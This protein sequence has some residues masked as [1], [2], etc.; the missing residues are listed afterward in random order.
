MKKKIT[1]HQFLFITTESECESGQ[2]HLVG[3]AVVIEGRVEV[4]VNGTWG[5]VCDDFWG[6]VDARV[7]CRQL[8]YSDQ[9]K[10]SESKSFSIF[11]MSITIV[12]ETGY[13][14]FRTRTTPIHLDNMH[15]NG[16]EESL[17]QCRYN[18][19]GIHNCRGSDGASVLCYNGKF[20]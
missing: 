12:Y 7:V 5:G 2:I 16:N 10:Q 6:G 11:T 19:V 1:L 3:G 14:R 13:G 17:F 9:C 4:C 15:C 20:T 18:G 8:G